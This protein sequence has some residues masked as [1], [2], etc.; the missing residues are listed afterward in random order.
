MLRRYLL[1]QFLLDITRLSL[2]GAADTSLLAF[3]F[4]MI[5]Q[6]S[7]FRFLLHED[8]LAERRSKLASHFLTR[9]AAWPRP[10]DINYL[11]ACLLQRR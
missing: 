3:D 10:T 9:N 8:V 7:S 6:P 11:C 4:E 5:A 1:A 2:E